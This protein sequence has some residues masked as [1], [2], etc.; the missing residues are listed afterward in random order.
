MCIIKDEGN[1]HNFGHFRGN[2]RQVLLHKIIY[3]FK[4]NL[5]DE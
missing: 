4:Y 3:F 2:T 1:E 5:P